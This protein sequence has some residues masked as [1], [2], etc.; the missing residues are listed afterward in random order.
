MYA[1]SAAWPW[2]DFTS[3]GFKVRTL[4]SEVNTNSETY[5]YLAI[6]EHPFKFANAR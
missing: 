4:D 2:C 6:A 3:N 5:I 1:E